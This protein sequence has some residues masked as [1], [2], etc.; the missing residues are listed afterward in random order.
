MMFYFSI[1]SYEFFFI[2]YV[3]FYCFLEYVVI[4]IKSKNYVICDI[5]EFVKEMYSSIIFMML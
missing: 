3:D 5:I 4:M 1:C 2:I